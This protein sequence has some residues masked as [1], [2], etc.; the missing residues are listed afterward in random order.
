MPYFYTNASSETDTEFLKAVSQLQADTNENTFTKYT[1][2]TITEEQAVANLKLHQFNPN[3]IDSNGFIAMGFRPKLVHTVLNARRKNWHF[4]NAES[5]EK[6]YG[7][8]PAEFEKIAPFISIPQENNF[9]KENSF[10]KNEF[11]KP[12]ISKVELNSCDTTLLIQLPMIGSKLASNIIKYREMLGQFASI[13]QLKDVYGIQAETFE[14]IKPYISVNTSGITKINLNEATY[15]ELKKHPYMK[16]ELL[17][18]IMNLRKAKKYHFNSL[19]EI[20]E[21]ELINDETFRKIAYYFE[22]R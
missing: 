17:D 13:E 16:G 18:K 3:L 5:F 7:L 15:E 12:T 10:T 22:V 19:S 20:K 1:K 8:Y 21:I 14:L 11:K 4:Y 9:N 2:E 6:M